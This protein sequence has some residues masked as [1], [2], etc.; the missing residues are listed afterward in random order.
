MPD[1]LDLAVNSPDFLAHVCPH[2]RAVGHVDLQGAV[3]VDGDA[4]VG[5]DPLVVL[6][7]GGDKDSLFVCF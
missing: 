2:V 4:I 3:A 1:G 5:F 6:Q 7:P